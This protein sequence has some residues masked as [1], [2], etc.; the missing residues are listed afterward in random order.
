MGAG[1]AT[2]IAFRDGG[3]PENAC[4]HAVL[5]DA[6]V[7]YDN[8]PVALCLNVNNIAVRTYETVC[9]DRGDA[10]TARGAPSC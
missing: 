7:S 4:R 8:G 10:F 3:A 2:Q 1:G 9:L 5:F 6:M